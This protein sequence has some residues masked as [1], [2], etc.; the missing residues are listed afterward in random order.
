M[1]YDLAII[2]GGSAAFSAGIRARHKRLNVVMIERGEIGGTCVNVGCIP[3]K[4]LLAAAD[5]HH[6]AATRRFPGIETTAAAVHMA[7]LIASK[8]VIVDDLRGRKYSDLARAYGWDIVRGAARFAPGPVVEVDGRR[9]EAEHYLIATGSIPAVPPIEGLTDVSYLTSTTAMELREI[10]GSLIVIGGNYIGL[11]LGQLFARLGS[12]VTIVEAFDR[13]APHDEPE[14]STVLADILRDEG[15]ALHTAATVTRARLEHGGVVVTV[16]RR[17]RAEDLR[18]SRLL[19][20]TGRRPETSSLNLD[21]VGVAT[22]RKGEIVVG[23]QLR[24][25]NPRIWAAGDVTGHPQFVYVAGVQGTIVVD[26]AFD[27]AGRHVD[28]RALPRVTFTTPNIASVGLTEDEAARGG[29]ECESRSIPLDLVPRALVNH[30]PRGVVKIVAERRTGTV[31]GIHMLAANAGDAI[32]A[33]VYA[34]ECQMTVQQL[35]NIW[36]PYLTISEGIKL[37]AQAFTMD[38]VKLSCCGG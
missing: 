26:N 20:A 34:I 6:A 17:G 1:I 4:A 22:G 3:S 35:A 37:A 11:E 16:D 13:I 18:A 2:G 23:S 25:A 24:T 7:A 32:L 29:F 30:D 31:R 36:A 8:D 28:Y 38:V 10:P 15:L 9:I 14:I 12:R 5:A 33:G 19:I 27:A 21:A